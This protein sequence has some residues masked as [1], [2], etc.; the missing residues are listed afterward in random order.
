L[1]PRPSG[2]GDRLPAMPLT[3]RE[4]CSL[5][6]GGCEALTGGGGGG[7]PPPPGGS[8]TPERSSGGR[9]FEGKYF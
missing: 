4:L 3:P 9:V 8:L 5:G 2:P 1:V 7:G 6:G